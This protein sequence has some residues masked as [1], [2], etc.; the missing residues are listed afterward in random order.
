[1][2]CQHSYFDTRDHPLSR[3]L[4]AWR[5]RIGHVLDVPISRA[6][7]ADGFHGC[8]DSWRVGDLLFMDC[9]TGSYSQSRPVTR[10]ST[11]AIRQYVFHVAVE[12]HISTETGLYPRRQA[13]QSQPGILAL[14]MNQPMWMERS[15]CRLFAIFVPRAL[16]DSVLPNAEA[17]HGRVVE[18]QS[19]L[20]RLIP[21]E[22]VHLRQTLSDM[23]ADQAY[24][25]IRDVALLLA[26]AFGRQAGLIGDARIALRSVLFGKVRRYIDAHLNQPD[27]TPD[28][29][30][31][32]SGLSRPTLYRLFEHEGGLAAY[33]RTRRLREA[34][35][36]LCVPSG[37]AVID[38][39]Y[40]LGFGSAAAFNHAFRRAYDMAPLDFRAAA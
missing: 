14:D 27:L 21:A 20:A 8:M 19:P 29:V 3:Q 18:Y 33:I 32:A 5:D 16:V 1:M 36:E 39:A 11:D 31:R 38:I 10:I 22:L 15:A 17:I 2:E 35:D 25:A 7:L 26:A 37:R 34:A 30:L 4:P 28:S 24:D 23:T 9:R 12:G 13:V 6:Q 40:G